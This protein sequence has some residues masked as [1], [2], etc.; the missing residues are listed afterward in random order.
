[1][2]IKFDF[3]DISLKACVLS[4]IKSRKECNPYI[5]NK[6]PI[7][8]APMDM[9]LDETNYK[10]FAKYFEVCLPRTAETDD[11]TIFKSYGLKEVKDMIE[12]NIKPHKRVLIDVA[13]GHSREVYNLAKDFKNKYPENILMVGN[14]ANPE[15]Y[16]EYAKLG[17][18]Y[19]RVSI[20][21]GSGCL[22]AVQ[23][24]VNYPMA[25]LID[26]IHAIKCDGNYSTKIIADG[27]FK[28]YSDIIKA[29]ALGADYVMVGGIFN[30][31]IESSSPTYYKSYDE[32]IELDKNIAES[33]FN[34]GHLLYKYYRGMSTK[35]VQQKWGKSVL[36]TSEGITKYNKVEYTIDGWTENFVD[37]LRSAMSYTDSRDL[38][39]FKTCDYV[40]ITENAYN[41]F[42]K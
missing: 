18:D 16:T 7:F 10:K 12:H 28:K 25:S 22:S 37:Y 6:L 19:I 29:L 15:T 39:S 38:K 27:G 35:E 17:V 13:N 5:N 33:Y 41:R 11:E 34:S 31:C 36:K 4:D 21:S 20:G 24:G 9:V 14:I 42:K 2:N 1:M 32:Y 3:D 8:V 40:R 23:T 26:E 30:K